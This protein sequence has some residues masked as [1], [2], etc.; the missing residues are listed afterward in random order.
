LFQKVIDRP[1]TRVGSLGAAAYASRHILNV[2]FN[3]VLELGGYSFLIMIISGNVV[4]N[5][6]EIDFIVDWCGIGR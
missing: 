2:S 5:G 6:S 3:T 1:E 4:V